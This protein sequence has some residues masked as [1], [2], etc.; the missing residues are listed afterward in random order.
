MN[1]EHQE[2]SGYQYNS[3]ACYAC[4]PNGESEGK[5]FRLNKSKI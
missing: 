2:V 4:H 1:E 5:M 3:D